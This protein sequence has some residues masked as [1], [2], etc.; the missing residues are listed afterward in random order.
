[1]FIY[2]SHGK[3]IFPPVL[4]SFP[5][6]A[7]FTKVPAP[8]CWAGSATPAFSGLLV[9]L[10]FCGGFPLPP[11]QCSRHLALFATCHFCCYYSVSPFSLGWGQSVQGAMLICPRVVCGSTMCHLAH[12]VVC[13]FTNILG[14]DIWWPGSPPGFSI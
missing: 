12:L 11:L 10:Q 7:T 5:L 6:T 2:S 8:G 9:Y 14:A 13:V 1:M 4:W 3:W